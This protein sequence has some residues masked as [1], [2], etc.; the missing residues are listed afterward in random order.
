MS[1]YRYRV[2]VIRIPRAMGAKAWPAGLHR[3][4]CQSVW[5]ERGLGAPDWLVFISCT[6]HVPGRYGHAVIFR[7]PPSGAN[8]KS[9]FFLFPLLPRPRRTNQRPTRQ[10]LAAHRR[11][12][13]SSSSPATAP[14]LSALLGCRTAAAELRLSRSTSPLLG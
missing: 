10:L 13:S 9:T 3:V 1:I 14:R 2:L 4:S 11:P 7:R 8:K 5:L 12:P 6:S